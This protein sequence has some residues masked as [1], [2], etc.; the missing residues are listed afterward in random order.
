MNPTISQ[1]PDVEGISNGLNTLDSNGQLVLI[2]VLLILLVFSL[3]TYIVYLAKVSSEDEKNEAKN[4]ENS[5]DL[6]R[7]TL[8]NS[9][10][11]RQSFKDATS[12][13]NTAIG[14]LKQDRLDIK[15][16][17]ELHDSSSARR[18]ENIRNHFDLRFDEVID[19]INI[20]DYEEDE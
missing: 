15:K 5:Y 12:A 8:S 2:V 17:I 13:F 10:E 7:I 3:V 19:T 18:A 11:D 4:R 9:S 6:V 14:L 16:W 1:I 20:K